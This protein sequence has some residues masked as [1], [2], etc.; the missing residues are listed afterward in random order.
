MI[1]YLTEHSIEFKVILD[2]PYYNKNNK[3]N[4]EELKVVRVIFYSAIQLFKFIK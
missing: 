2:V 4:L 1:K 3:K